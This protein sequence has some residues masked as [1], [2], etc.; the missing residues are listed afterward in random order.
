MEVSFGQLCL[1]MIYRIGDRNF[2]CHPRSSIIANH[3]LLE[4]L[5]E[6]NSLNH[7]VPS[8]GDILLITL[9]KSP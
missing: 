4:Y 1:D 9:C 6:N 8:P 2:I 5:S 7:P 3:L